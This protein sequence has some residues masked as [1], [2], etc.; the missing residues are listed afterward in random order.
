MFRHILR[1]LGLLLFLLLFL[2]IVAASALQ[3]ASAQALVSRIDGQHR[4][5]AFVLSLD[6]GTLRISHTAEPARIL[7]AS[8][9]GRAFLGAAQG[10]AD[11]RQFGTPDGSYRIDDRLLAQCLTQSIEALDSAADTL[12]VRG[13]LRGQGCDVAY[14]LT[15]DAAGANQLRFRL[16]L[17]GPQAA[18]L[19]RSFLR[20]ASSADERYFGLGQQLSWFDQKGKTIP[21]LVQEHG[22]GRGLPGFTQLFDLLEGGGGGSEVS[23]GAPAPYYLSSKLNSLF[24]ENTEYSIFDF[25]HPERVEIT[26]FT[27]ALTGRILYGRTPLDLCAALPVHARVGLH[28]GAGGDARCAIGAAVPAGRD[29]DQPLD[30]PA[31]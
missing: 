10:Q 5:G 21:V 14:S 3:P 8:I 18:Q 28:G 4:V 29:L 11:I 25:R 22:V 16:Q 26:L 23:T 12:V 17:D 15:F 27:S 7:W 20:H 30:R 31:C 24:L 1:R 13:R 2:F 19:N 9:P 6:A